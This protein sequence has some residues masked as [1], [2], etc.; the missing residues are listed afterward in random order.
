M[1]SKIFII[2]LSMKLSLT[3]KVRSI[4]FSLLLNSIISINTTQNPKWQVTQKLVV[5]IIGI[6][7]FIVGF[8]I[9]YPEAKKAQKARK[10]FIIGFIAGFIV[11]FLAVLLQYILKQ[12]NSAK[13]KSF[14]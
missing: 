7:S 10:A 12:K 4:Y 1:L 8:I 14:S 2:N 11:S 5:I 9:A 6:I 3:T 13:L